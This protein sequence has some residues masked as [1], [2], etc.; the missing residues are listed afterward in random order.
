MWLDRAR[1]VVIYNDPE[2]AER[3]VRS[4]PGAKALDSNGYF[5]FPNTLYNLQLARWIG[6][7]VPPPLADY[8]WPGRFTPFAK[9]RDMANFMTVHPRC[10]NLSLIH[11]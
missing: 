7:P 4:V 3:V 11:I 1:N 6:L 9:Q 2:R 5:A 10:L 8:D